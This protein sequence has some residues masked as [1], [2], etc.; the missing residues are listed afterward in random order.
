MIQVWYITDF[1]ILFSTKI[2]EMTPIKEYKVGYE[3]LYC[4]RKKIFREVYDLLTMPFWIPK[5]RDL[6]FSAG[7]IWAKSLAVVNVGATKKVFTKVLT[8]FFLRGTHAGGYENFFPPQPDKSI[9]FYRRD[10]R[11]DYRKQAHKNSAGFLLSIS[12][13]SLPN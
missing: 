6:F 9:P 12:S 8:V 13:L 7:Q 2:F 3:M 4:I 11:N 1:V 5:W 10:N